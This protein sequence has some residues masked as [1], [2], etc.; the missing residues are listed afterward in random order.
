MAVDYF[1]KMR[2]A[3]EKDRQKR[4]QDTVQ[5]TAVP[6]DIAEAEEAFHPLVVSAQTGKL[7]AGEHVA[8][9]RGVGATDHMIQLNIV[10]HLQ[11]SHLLCDTPKSPDNKWRVFRRPAPPTSLWRVLPGFGD[12]SRKADDPKATP[13]ST[14]SSNVASCTFWLLATGFDVDRRNVFCDLVRSPDEL[15]ICP[16]FGIEYCEKE[17]ELEQALEH[18]ITTASHALY[19]RLLLRKA[20][21]QAHNPSHAYEPAFDADGVISYY[22]ITLSQTSYKVYCI[23]AY[24]QRRTTRGPIPVSELVH[25]SSP[26]TTSN[27]ADILDTRS[28]RSISSYLDNAHNSHQGGHST[29]TPK[30]N[31]KSGTLASS[32][33]RR[34]PVSTSA[35]RT[36]FTGSA[37]SV[38]VSHHSTTDGKDPWA[39]CEVTRIGCGGCRNLPSLLSLVKW[40]NEIHK[41]GQSVHAA[42]V[43]ADLTTYINYRYGEAWHMET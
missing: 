33:P 18:L 40:V 36:G 2:D 29:Q 27:P 13:T 38:S 31:R 34:V 5:R 41:W 14:Y 16:Y 3:A 22:G 12:G 32:P 39:G 28:G 23:T 30:G 15:S 19:D 4:A 8:L 1:K 25:A 21:A 37:T 6:S 7:F 42:A 17:G 10:Q 11:G 20:A 24:G 35:I 26:T 43:T 9:I